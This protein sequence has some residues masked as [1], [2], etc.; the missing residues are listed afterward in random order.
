MVSRLRYPHVLNQYFK[1][2]KPFGHFIR[3]LL[4]LALLFFYHQIAFVLMFCGFAASSLV[5]WI[6]FRA[7]VAKYL[8]KLSPKAI[9]NEENLIPSAG[10]KAPGG[11]HSD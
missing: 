7:P 5:K 1:G 11:A 6:Y 4:L 8:A 9:H 2:K 3:V 10:D